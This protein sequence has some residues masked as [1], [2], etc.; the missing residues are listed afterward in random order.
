MTDSM[1]SVP[2]IHISLRK[3]Y[4]LSRLGGPEAVDPIFVAARYF[5][6]F[7][8]SRASTDFVIYS[9]ENL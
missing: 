8:S 6:K 2:K 1:K 9:Y 5:S 4:P 7:P 3:T